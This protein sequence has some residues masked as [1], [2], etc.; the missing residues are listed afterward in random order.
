M[1]E[2]KFQQFY[3]LFNVGVHYLSFPISGEMSNVE[4]CGAPLDL[5]TSMVKV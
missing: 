4:V 2:S 5:G 3:Y 1:V